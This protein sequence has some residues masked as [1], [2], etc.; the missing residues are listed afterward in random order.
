MKTFDTLR[1]DLGPDESQPSNAIADSGTSTFDIERYSSPGE[2]SDD[3]V[4]AHIS[5][6]DTAELG[7]WVPNAGTSA[8]TSGSFEASS[9]QTDDGAN[10]GDVSSETVG[11][12]ISP[13]IEP[14]LVGGAAGTADG[15]QVGSEVEQ[16]A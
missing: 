2:P 14:Y 1:D 13:V 5:F 11:S 10:C 3:A 12:A 6:V 8:D 16:T 15:T 4:S 7:N 9:N